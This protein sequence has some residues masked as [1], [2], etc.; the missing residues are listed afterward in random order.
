MRAVCPG[1]GG[2]LFHYMHHLL[3][4]AP[5]LNLEVQMCCWG[6][7]RATTQPTHT[8]CT[9]LLTLGKEE[10]DFSL[11]PLHFQTCANVKVPSSCVDSTLLGHV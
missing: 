3:F 4:R 6:H 9:I 8:I 11:I 7:L 2:H 5:T 10:E 1:A